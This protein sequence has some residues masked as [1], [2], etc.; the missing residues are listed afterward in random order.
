MDDPSLI[1]ELLESGSE[2]FYFYV[3]YIPT[4]K[5]GV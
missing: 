1:I 4:N 2:H 5:W 3:L